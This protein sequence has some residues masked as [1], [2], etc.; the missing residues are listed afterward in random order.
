[1]FRPGWLLLCLATTLEAIPIDLS[2]LRPGPVT[3]RAIA[4]GLIVSWADEKGLPWSIEF[5]ADGNPQV[6]R[7]ISTEGKSVI[8]NAQPVYFADTGLRR[9]GWDQFF[10]F[11]PSHP[12]GIRRFQQEFKPTSVAAHTAGN[13][14]EVR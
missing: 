12:A 8:E 9:G 6:L 14:L 5:R 11:P 13:R 10:D 7:R 4:D 1:M 2:G 3:V